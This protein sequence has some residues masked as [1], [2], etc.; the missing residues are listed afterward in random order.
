MEK[1][2]E[3]QKK[4]LVLAGITVMVYGTLRFL[5]PLVIPFFI[6]WAAALLLRPSARWIADKCRIRI[7]GRYRGIPVGIVGVA[8]LV[9][10]LALTFAGMYFGGR[11]LCVEISMFA[12]RFPIWVNGVDRWLT[13]LCH[14]LEEGLCLTPGCL[15][16][17]AREMLRGLLKTVQNAAMPYLMANSVSI[18]RWGLKL[19]VVTV[20]IL[21]AVGLALQE[22]DDWKRRLGRSLFREEYT[23]IGRRLS[24]VADAYVKTQGIIMLLTT[25]ICMAGLWLMGNPY[26]ILAGIGIGILDALPVFGTGTVL[27]PWALFLFAGKR[28]G[29][30]VT[31]LGLYL[32]CYFLREILEAKM[33]GD[34]VGLSPLENLISMYV[35]LELFG[36]L[37][38]LLGPV[39]VL[40]IRDLARAYCQM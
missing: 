19:L 4:A 9:A 38:L 39:G 17:L 12:E 2:G 40:L 34:R 22:M 18:F 27:I 7:R 36:I 30:G 26:Y 13:S 6:A 31:L 28:W 3:K 32:I 25:G 33:M 35:G 10:F 5:L 23:L 24:I 37:G 16:R 15:V 11:K 8:E 14:R 1:A 20:I 29:S 21:V